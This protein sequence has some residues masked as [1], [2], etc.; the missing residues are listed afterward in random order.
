MI[1][2]N[3]RIGVRPRKGSKISKEYWGIQIWV[4]DGD[5]SYPRLDTADEHWRRKDPTSILKLY[6]TAEQADAAMRVWWREFEEARK[7]RSRY[8]NCL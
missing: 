8:D 5:V 2:T 3:R 4:A 6:D 1:G 7:E